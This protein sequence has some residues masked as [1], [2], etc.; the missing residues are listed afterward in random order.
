MSS[1]A[2][3][4]KNLRNARPS[5]KNWTHVFN[6]SAFVESHFVNSGRGWIL[7]L[8]ADVLREPHKAHSAWMMQFG[9]AVSLIPREEAEEMGKGLYLEVMNKG[10]FEQ[11]RR[12][13]DLY[14]QHERR[15]MKLYMR[16]IQEIS[17]KLKLPKDKIIELGLFPRTA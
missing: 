16:P 10:L 15:V 3:R 11:T 7:E 6:I 17:S 8:C 1:F 4:I 2:T 5:K 9:E 13:R 14:Y 12:Y